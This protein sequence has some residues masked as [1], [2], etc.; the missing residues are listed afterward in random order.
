M[1]QS[2]TKKIIVIAS[3]HKIAS[4][5]ILLIMLGM[6]YFGYDAVFGAVS[7]T[8]SVFANVEKGT[9][10]SYVTGSG[11]VSVSTQLDIKPKVSA[12]IVY[13][14]VRPGQYM[15]SHTLLVQ[16]DAREAEKQVRDA[17]TNLDS[18]RL[19]LQKLQQP[20]DY[21]SILQTEHALDQA[22]EARYEAENNL[23]QTYDNGFNTVA[24][25][26]L[27]LSPSMTGLQSILFSTTLS[28]ATGAQSNLAYYADMVKDYDARSLDYKEHAYDAYQK[29]RRAYDANFQSY[30]ALTRFSD[31]DAVESL[32]DETYDTTRHVAESIKSLNNF[33]QFYE[34]KLI[35]HNI[36]PNPVAHTHLADLNAYAGH[37]NNHLLDLLSIKNTIESH[38]RSFIN[39][40]RNV[41]EK[42]AL[43]EKLESGADPLDVETQEL[44]IKQR[45][46]ALVDAQEK[47]N[48]YMIR[49]PFDGVVATLD[50]KKG[51]SVTTATTIVTLITPKQLAE[52]SMNEVDVA[53]VD[54]GDRATIT[55]DA[56]PDVRM[57]GMVAEID[58]I[59]T[60]SQ[61]VVSYMVSIG[62]DT[63]DKRIKPGM[64]VSAS[65]M[66]DT[67]TNVLL[68]PNAAIKAQN[69]MHY[70]EMPNNIDVSGNEMA[71]AVGVILSQPITRKF[72]EV[73]MSNDEVTEIISGL[74]EGNV[75]ITRSMSVS[76]VPYTQQ[77]SSAFRLPG[78]PGGGGRGGFRTG[79]GR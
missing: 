36:K 8:R 67:K 71:Y 20:P 79:E 11:Q 48:E 43:L 69:G 3:T 59:G 68:L 73:G 26:F 7:A 13:I 25:A 24:N 14:G 39:A 61:G 37:I 74:D 32:I 21:P 44:V 23:P 30:K 54:V 65:V 51:D 2:M 1:L 63:Q 19:A 6:G 76:P 56:L 4:L 10:V 15:A 16:L 29:A 62:F 75:V 34:D 31:P 49:A 33:I 46:H 66:I 40:E 60:I 9:I 47:L 55:F 64:S 78:L 77:T 72:I 52:I 22:Q 27:D 12:D 45:E 28:S 50:V 5:M 38:K 70:V 42:S 18:A 41:L 17:Q 35:E 58:T 57:T 53:K